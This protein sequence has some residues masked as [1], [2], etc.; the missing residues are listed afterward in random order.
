MR[1]EYVYTPVYRQHACNIPLTTMKKKNLL[2][3]ATSLLPLLLCAQSP[4]FTTDAAPS[5]EQQQRWILVEQEA[6]RFRIMSPGP[7]QEKV[8]SVPTIM[9]MMAYHTFFFQPPNEL[10]DNAV[11][12]LSYCDYPE[13]S[14]HSDSTELV[15]EFF[16]ATVASAAESVGGNVRYSDVR[17]VY[18]FPGRVWRI[19]YNNGRASVH[20]H[21]CVVGNRY[22]A[23]QTVSRRE[24]A[25]NRWSDRFI[26]SFEVVRV[27]PQTAEPLPKRRK[28]QR[29]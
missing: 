14:L 2:L 25:L 17:N 1:Y 18:E 3:Y 15:A 19:D 7:L 4:E 20:T 8:D 6:G 21:A 29:Q 11:Y 13:G 12:M 28:R 10:A 22:Y 27:E 16:E 23:V 26:N 9:G 5:W 24:L